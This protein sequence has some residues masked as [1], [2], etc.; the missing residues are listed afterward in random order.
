MRFINNS[1]RGLLGS[2]VVSTQKTSS[3]TITAVKISNPAFT[4][5]VNK[6]AVL[7]FKCHMKITA[8]QQKNTESIILALHQIQFVKI[9]RM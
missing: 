8:L 4:N 5:N 7:P 9:E 1:S 6:T 3:R 2:N